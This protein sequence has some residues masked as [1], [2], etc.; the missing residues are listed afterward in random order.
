MT[1]DQLP[2]R[3]GTP[4]D[5][6]AVASLLTRVFHDT[7][8]PDLH[9][10]EREIFEPD[11]S[12]IVEDQG[13][14]VAHAGSFTRELTVPG[15]VVP[16]AHVTM[17][18]VAPTHRRR[19]LL[20]RSMH[21]QL[22]EILAAGREPVAVLWASEGRIYP[23][24]GYGQAAQLLRL[25]VDTRE[26]KINSPAAAASGRL[27]AGTPGALQVELAKVYE[28]L[29][30]DRPGWS[31]RDDRWWRYVLADPPAR[32]HG[33][34]ERRA[35]VHEGPVGVDGYA[36]WRSKSAWD[37]SGPNG[38]VIVNAIVAGTPEAYGALWGFLLGIDL[39]RTVTYWAAA[40]DEP[41]L[42]VVNEP[43]RLKPMLADSLWVRLVDLPSA[44]AARRY[45]IGVDAV[46]EV[47]DALLP[48]N[49]GRWRL[50]GDVGGASC[51]RTDAAPDLACD[52]VD[53]AAAYLG[54][55]SLAALAGAG[56][57]RELRPGS[58]GPASAA[59]GWHRA[60]AAHEIF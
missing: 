28:Q 38:E 13:G 25:R 35:V 48:E 54:G 30:P 1:E 58:L 44:L 50:V 7:P 21:R 11:R 4:D 2:I 33:G 9:E 53:L 41:L 27:R 29:R 24:F 56:R 45:A 57:V 8:D 42:H 12:L 26:V 20:T 17:V 14:V 19:G 6:D 60:P 46:F 16:A 43:R 49:R 47:T 34:T 3:I 36:L 15:A 18:G 52:V 55:V 32:R 39:T 22:V 5:W 23:R 10:I 40:V 31:N 59:F 37:E 51:V